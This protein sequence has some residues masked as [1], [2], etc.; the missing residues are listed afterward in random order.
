MIRDNMRI[1]G[2]KDF[3]ERRDTLSGLYSRLSPD[4]KM[5]YKWYIYSRRYLRE[6]LCDAMWEYLNAATIEELADASARL[7][8]AYAKYRCEVNDDKYY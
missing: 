2:F 6:K 7:A 4:D 8:Q 3:Y 1:G 5:V